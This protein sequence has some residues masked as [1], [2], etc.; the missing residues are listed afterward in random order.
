MPVQSWNLPAAA[1]VWVALSAYLVPGKW[2]LQRL[3][4]TSKA[5]KEAPNPLYISPPLQPQ[6]HQPL[7]EKSL[8][9]GRFEQLPVCFLSISLRVYIKQ[10]LEC[11]MLTYQ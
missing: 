4:A 5:E 3:T 6:E 2:V 11:R 1:H 8:I 9:P 10:V 7:Q